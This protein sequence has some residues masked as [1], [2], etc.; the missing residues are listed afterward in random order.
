MK[1][2][3]HSGQLPH[4]EVDLE[5]GELGVVSNCTEFWTTGG[6]V[7]FCV[8]R[9]DAAGPIR[10]TDE[11]C[12]GMVELN[13]CWYGWMNFDFASVSSLENTN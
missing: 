2:Q 11:V 1:R 3:G 10:D 7:A 4:S 8:L 12:D 5:I 9:E 6:N 13:Q